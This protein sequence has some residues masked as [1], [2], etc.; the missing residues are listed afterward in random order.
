MVQLQLIAIGAG[1]G[2]FPATFDNVQYFTLLPWAVSSNPSHITVHLQHLSYILYSLAT[3]STSELRTLCLSYVRTYSP[4]GSGVATGTPPAHCSGF[5]P[6]P[7]PAA[8]AQPLG[9]HHLKPCKILRARDGLWGIAG[10][11]LWPSCYWSWSSH[12]HV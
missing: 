12:T 3:Y 1:R 5:G 10:W 8:C 11:N 9:T 6:A 4:D 2:G 7:C